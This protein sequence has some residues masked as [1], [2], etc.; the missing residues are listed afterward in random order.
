M[1]GAYTK[2]AAFNAAGAHVVSRV[3]DSQRVLAD[4]SHVQM[5]R[6]MESLLQEAG[7]DG[8]AVIGVG[9]AVPGEVAAEESLKLCPHLDL[10]LRSYKAFLLD[11]LPKA[12]VAV[13][14]DADAAV[15][16]DRWLGASHNRQ[17][18]NVAFI[19]LGTGTG[20]GIVAHGRLFSGV[21]GAAGEFGHLFVNP[22]EEVRCAC[23]KAG[24][25]EQYASAA[26]LVHHAREAFAAA[27]EGATDDE[28]VAAFPDARTVLDAAENDNPAAC[29]ALERFSDA[30]GFGLAQM[31][32]LVDPDVFVLGGGLSERAD[33]FI[34]AVRLRYRA[35][36]LPV[37][38]DTPIVASSLGSECGAYGAAYRAFQQLDKNAPGCVAKV[39]AM[40]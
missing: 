33:L 6:E 35:C 40:R 25:L 3:F 20:A 18:E 5:S 30:L 7:I 39:N 13:V 37:C 1:G 28:A 2:V 38:V 14:N 36:V 8:H 22:N 21:H 29:A 9:L 34:D 12:R 10:N 32:C 24:C 16:G 11:L 15:L 31:A 23:G 17:D 19:T 4:G 27:N 26:G